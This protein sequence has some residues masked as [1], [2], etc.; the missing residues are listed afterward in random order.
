M[1]NGE[2]SSFEN[3]REKLY[4]FL[5]H[6]TDCHKFSSLSQ[7]I[8]YIIA[9]VGELCPLPGWPEPVCGLE[10]SSHL[11]SRLAMDLFPGSF[12]VLENLLSD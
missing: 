2:L 10:L 7:H 4:Y 8:Y 5:C 3:V 1:A 9:S 6:P 12:R 11:G